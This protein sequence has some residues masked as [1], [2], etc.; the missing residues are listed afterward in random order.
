MM[1]TA[2]INRLLEER[3]GRRPWH[4]H[5]DPLSELIAVILSQ[6]TSDANSGRAFN[7]LLAAFGTWEEVAAVEVDA[8]EQV[9][10]SGGLSRVK[11]ARIKDILQTISREHGSLDLTFLADMDIDEA[12]TWLKRLPGVGPKTAACVLLFALG[13]PVFPVDTH[14]YR[15]S[16][17]LGLIANGASAEKAH[18]LLGNMIASESVYQFHMNMV[19]HGRRICRARRPKCPECVLRSDCPSAARLA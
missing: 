5:H 16:R 19:E 11:A 6:N 8:I 13:R 9:I 17:R 15:V 4:Q 2:R 14:V 10:H 3:Y 18:E 1:D 12:G 7:S